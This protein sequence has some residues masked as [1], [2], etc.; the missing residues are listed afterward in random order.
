MRRRSS[1]TGAHS[2]AGA[3]S[4]AG[5]DL[6]R[7][8]A[9]GK[10][11]DDDVE[12][13][14]TTPSLPGTNGNDN[15]L[16]SGAAAAGVDKAVRPGAPGYV[17]PLAAS[18]A[19]PL[20]I[21]P[22][23]SEAA[24]SLHLELTSRVPVSSME[25]ET[26]GVQQGFVRQLVVDDPQVEG[27]GT[28]EGEEEDDAE[29]KLQSAARSSPQGS[30]VSVYHVSTMAGDDVS[31]MLEPGGSYRMRFTNRAA[32]SAILTVGLKVVDK[33]LLAHAR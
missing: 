14:V 28:V 26:G 17:D 15:P 10:L 23:S 24:G 13:L 4:G 31:F 22:P 20:S 9:R 18:A 1:E 32:A 8:I 29:E 11:D 21:P 30:V 25:T 19:P 5:A 16:E 33:A 6:A 7:R 12:S 2:G 27:K 3:G